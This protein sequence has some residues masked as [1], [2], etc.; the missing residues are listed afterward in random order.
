[1]ALAGT[2]RG[3]GVSN[4]ATLT[5]TLSPSG[6]F[7]TGS[8]AVLTVAADNGGSSGAHNLTGVSDSLGNTWTL[9]QSPLND[10]G[11]ASAGV[12]G[13]IATTNQNIG[14]L[15]TGTVITV[16]FGN[17]SSVVRAWT[18]QEIT[19]AAGKF[20]FYV[21]GNVSGAFTTAPTL[22]TASITSGDAVVAALFIEQGTGNAITG[23]AD[24]SNGSWSAQQ[25]TSVG[26]TT[27]GI[28][29]ASQRKIVSGTATQTYNPTHSVVGDGILA[30]IQL[31]E[32]NAYV[33]T[34]ASGAFTLS[35]TAAVLKAG[36]YITAASGTVSLAGTAASLKAGR[37]LDATT[38]G[39]YALAMTAA[40]LKHGRYLGANG[41]AYTYTGTAATLKAG[42]YLGAGIGAYTL[43]G[44][45]ATLTYTPHSLNN[46][47]LTA[48]ALTLTLSLTAASLTHG[49]VLSASAGAY[50][51]ALTA[52]TLLHKRVLAASAGTVALSLTSAGLL[53]GR[54]LT[55]SASA[56][57]LSLTAAS[58]KY[59]H[60]LN[61]APGTFALGLIAASLLASHKL[62]AAA[63][64]VMLAGQNVGL[65]HGRTLAANGGTV[66]LAG[67]SANLLIGR[68][69]A[70]DT[71]ALT[72][73]GTDLSL[74]HARLL[75][76]AV[77][78]F[79]F[80]SPSSGL[81]VGRYLSANGGAFVLA[82]P[83]AL[84]KYSGEGARLNAD[85][86]SI[87]LMGG[88]AAL[89][90]GYRL[91]AEGGAFGLAGNDIGLFY[92]RRLRLDSGA[93][94]HIGTDVALFYSGASTY[95]FVLEGGEYIFENVE[96]R[97][98]YSGPAY[99]PVAHPYI[100][101]GIYPN[102]MVTLRQCDDELLRL[103]LAERDTVAMRTPGASLAIAGMRHLAAL[104][105]RELIRTGHTY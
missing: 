104:R 57:V 95:T 49:R 45:N 54:L 8:M 13:V 69:L 68:R 85:A 3:V 10:P 77:G 84:L 74:L 9:R 20:V 78:A 43:A 28:G 70:A 47:T 15:Q 29:V 101:E 48:G 87:I 65:L 52:A 46:Y 11:A 33:L 23:D 18:L 31:R 35:M 72:L 12:Q 67:Q 26:T 41:G 97:L 39:T 76:A 103:T 102:A 92:G 24:V 19:C 7:A 66:I 58:L 61:A 94:L 2:D 62:A 88:P 36:R 21:G 60:V 16:T 51:L 80:E 63:G 91:A 6:N 14:P 90:H 89:L 40:V 64:A 30:Y 38:A 17:T 37:R 82:E 96:A 105:R 81:R 27:S 75:A 99:V 98:L 1:M 93:F 50:A 34:A 73:A 83:E 86:G 53:H 25:T 44:Q 100:G 4:T 55:A 56:Y 42:R 5:F 71:G 79:A 59:G 32:L 22:T